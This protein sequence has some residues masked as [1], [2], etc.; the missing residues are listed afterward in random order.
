MHET[1]T[2]KEKWSLMLK[3]VFQI[4]V[5]QVAMYLI[6]FFDILMSSRYGSMDLAGVAVGSSLWVPIYTGLAGILLAVTPI[7][8][9]LI[10]AKK[11]EDVRLVVQQGLYLSLA[12]SAIVLVLIYT[13][14]NPILSSIISTCNEYWI[15]SFVCI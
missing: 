9:Q 15:S 1:T 2:H 5:T 10:G 6:S 13:F 12:L 8:A 14:L 7:V 11:S 3:I 4:L